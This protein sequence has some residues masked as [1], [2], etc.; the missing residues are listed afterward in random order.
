MAQKAAQ[1]FSGFP[2]TAVGAKPGAFNTKRG[3]NLMKT[4]SIFLIF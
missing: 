4:A 1:G 3:I 2:H